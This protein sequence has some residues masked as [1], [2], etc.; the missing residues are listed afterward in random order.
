MDRT[1][2]AHDQL[3]M[4]N[5]CSNNIEWTKSQWNDRFIESVLLNISKA[6]LQ[7]ETSER[8]TS[9]KNEE[10][11]KSKDKKEAKKEAKISD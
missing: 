8:T 11:E 9:N 7:L 3:S 2:I 10:L 5:V 6:S 1:C 4:Q